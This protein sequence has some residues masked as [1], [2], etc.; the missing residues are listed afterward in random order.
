L[1]TFDKQ[2]EEFREL[3]E[4]FGLILLHNGHVLRFSRVLVD[5]IGHIAKRNGRQLDE[6]PEG[7]EEVLIVG[8]LADGAFEGGKVITGRLRWWFL[9]RLGRH[10]APLSLGK[11]RALSALRQSGPR[12]KVLLSG[13]SRIE[14]ASSVARAPFPGQRLGS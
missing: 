11:K 7:G 6:M 13:D 5:G 2:A 8:D 14:N 10:T 9:A 3:P 12:C 4:R 1:Q